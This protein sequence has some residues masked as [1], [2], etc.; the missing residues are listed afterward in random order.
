M[1]TFVL[2]VW[3]KTSPF[4]DGNN[5]T[6]VTVPGFASAAECAAAGEAA[7][8]LTNGSP[9]SGAKYACLKQTGSK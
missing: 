5:M 6:A 7:V 8:A 4:H 2:L 9:Q 3:F 1:I